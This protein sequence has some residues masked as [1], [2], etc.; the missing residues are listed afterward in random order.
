MPRVTVLLTSYNH[1]SFI[2]AAIQS[3]LEQTFSDWELLIVDDCSQDNSWETIHYWQTKD[4]RI[5]AVRNSC[6]MGPEHAFRVMDE[7]ASGEYVAVFH[8]DDLWDPIK[9]EKQ[10]AFLE[11]HTEIGAVFTGV[12]IIDETGRPRSKEIQDTYTSCFLTDN[13]TRHQWLNYFFYH[14][15]ALCH[16]S[17]L[18]RRELYRQC[19][20]FLEGLAQGPDFCKWI[21]LCMSQEIYILSDKLTYYRVLREEGN[22]SANTRK[23][24]MRSYLELLFIYRPYFEMEMEELAAVF[25]QAQRYITGQGA[26]AAF[27]AAKLFLEEGYTESMKLLGLEKL[28]ELLNQDSSRV[29]LQEL[30]GYGFPQF[31][32]DTRSYN[33]FHLFLDRVDNKLAFNRTV[34]YWRGAVFTPENSISVDYVM[35]EDGS[36]SVEAELPVGTIDALRVD[37]CQWHSAIVKMISFQC[38]GDEYCTQLKNGAQWSGGVDVFATLR[39][40]YYLFF[41]TPKEVRKVCI[42]AYL[43]QNLQVALERW[44]AFAPEVDVD[45]KYRCREMEKQETGG[46]KRGWRWRKN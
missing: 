10:V 5:I 9:L 21:R 46:K 42:K 30:Y 45:A 44:N 13:R 29:R 37:L 40:Q 12:K 4:S 28:Y 38:D 23:N 18:I 7:K 24:Q 22:T 2:G 6:R 1:G 14:G 35:L 36:I 43:T 20:L 19:G 31:I 41:E 25:P 16:P 3:V 17:V 32:E 33:I 11:A 15:N 26:D 27:A 34:F 39:A 8:S